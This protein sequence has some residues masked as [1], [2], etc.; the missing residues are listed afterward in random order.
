MENWKKAASDLLGEVGI[1]PTWP[2]YEGLLN[3]F[4]NW[5]EFGDIIGARSII[6]GSFV[7]G[8]AIFDTVKELRSSLK[9][10]MLKCGMHTASPTDDVVDD[11]RTCVD[12]LKDTIGDNAFGNIGI[13]HD[14]V[15][16]IIIKLMRTRMVTNKSFISS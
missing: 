13:A 2:M 14:E 5:V 10:R 15:I 4:D 8:L 7:V 6:S 16:E 9:D 11:F 1:E 12:F 3:E